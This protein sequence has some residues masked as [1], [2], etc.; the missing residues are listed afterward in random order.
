MTQQPTMGSPEILFRP[1]ARPEDEARQSRRTRALRHPVFSWLGLRPI[2]A[3]HTQAE[4]DTLLRWSA[5]RKYVVEIGVA[6]GA[7]ACALR[8]A[9]SSDGELWLIDPFHLSRMRQLNALK[10]AAHAAVARFGASRVR[11]IEQFSSDAIKNWR[12]PIDLLFIDGDHEEK[13]VLGDW[14]DWS[15][16]VS[17]GGVAIFHDARIFA[18]GWTVETDGPVRA[19][20]RLFRVASAGPWR[21]AEEVD[22]M[23]VVE[24]A[25]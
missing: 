8:Q 21:I 11:W 19:V 10:R 4:H 23:V 7:S 9:M 14:A 22:S 3:Q 25:K 5:G 1:F 24:R 17:P 16:F 18:G 15:P 2:F 6:E 12:S 13:A 20:D